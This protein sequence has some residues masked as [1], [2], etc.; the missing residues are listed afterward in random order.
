M[1]YLTCTKQTEK[2][3]F[4]NFGNYSKTTFGNHL[5]ANGYQNVIFCDRAESWKKLGNGSFFHH[6]FVKSHFKTGTMKIP[7]MRRYHFSVLVIIKE[8]F[9]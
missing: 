5:T 8:R 6:I 7:K 1:T 4:A 9:V 3:F 2:A